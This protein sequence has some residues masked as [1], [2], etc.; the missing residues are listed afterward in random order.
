MRR[1]LTCWSSVSKSI[2]TYTVLSGVLL[3]I[4]LKYNHGSYSSLSSPT[5]PF[6][7]QSSLRHE[8]G[9]PCSVRIGMAGGPDTDI[10]M[11]IVPLAP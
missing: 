4:G 11:S 8:V 10:Y 2:Y 1:F 9:L 3:P 5:L 7:D 6:P